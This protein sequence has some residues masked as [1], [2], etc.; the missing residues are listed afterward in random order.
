M[1]LLVGQGNHGNSSKATTRGKSI[2]DQKQEVG[3]IIMLFGT[4]EEWS[5]KEKIVSKKVNK[6]DLVRSRRREAK[7]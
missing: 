1:K 6:K 2:I 3:M 4:L 5:L 7:C